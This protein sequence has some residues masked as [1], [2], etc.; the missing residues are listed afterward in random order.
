MT[1]YIDR[2]EREMGG[3]DLG[4]GARV[5]VDSSEVVE[6][7]VEEEVVAIEE[8]EAEDQRVLDLPQVGHYVLVEGPNHCCD[9]KQHQTEAELQA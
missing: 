6:A 8:V 7:D 9:A 1:V 5:S 2:K 3:G 4:G